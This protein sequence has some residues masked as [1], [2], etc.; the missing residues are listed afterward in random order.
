MIVFGVQVDELF[1][2]W[3]L[4]KLSVAHFKVYLVVKYLGSYGAMGHRRK[5]TAHILLRYYTYFY[6][7]FAHR[8][9]AF[10]GVQ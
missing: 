4:S 5:V 1:D 9:A 10:A 2:S 3:K 8:A 7:L 6:F